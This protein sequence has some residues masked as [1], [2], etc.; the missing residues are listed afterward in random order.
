MESVAATRPAKKVQNDRRVQSQGNPF[1]EGNRPLDT[2]RS[3]IATVRPPFS[4]RQRYVEPLA[5]QLEQ[6][7]SGAALHDRQSESANHFT[8]E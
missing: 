4:N 8:S 5:L 7:R 6:T 1:V 3:T 2:F